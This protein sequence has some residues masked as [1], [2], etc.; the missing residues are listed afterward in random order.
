MSRLKEIYHH[1]VP[2]HIRWPLG[3]LRRDVHDGL[4]RLAPWTGPIPPRGVLLKVQS[5]PWAMEYLDIGKRSAARM[6]EVLHGAGLDASTSPRVLDFGSGLGRVLRH[7]GKTGWQLSGCD[8]DG[9]SIEWSRRVCG[10]AELKVSG[11]DPPLPWD[12]ATFDAVY[13]VSV[14]SH[15][16]TARQHSWAAELRRILKPGGWAI[17]TTMGP[18]V[19]NP[20]PPADETSK[21]IH[22]FWFVPA[23][24]DFNDSASIHTEEGLRYFFDPHLEMVAWHRGGLDGFQDLAL[25]RKT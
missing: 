15:F 3:R 24:K 14:F 9:A 5:T 1:R 25:F 11:D 20:L 7:L 16:P 23:G 12:D 19:F 2:A 17:V 18:W 6:Q 4:L 22:G 8:V 21:D 13:A 10:F